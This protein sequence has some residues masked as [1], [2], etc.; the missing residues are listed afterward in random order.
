MTKRPG[1]KAV[2]STWKGRIA[3]IILLSLITITI[4]YADNPATGQTTT[5]QKLNIFVQNPA[6]GGT[7][8][9]C[10][11]P[12]VVTGQTAIGELNQSANVSLAMPVTTSTATAAT[13]IFLTVRLAVLLP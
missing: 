2:L 12:L 5:G 4:A 8:N 13:V 7:V 6:N 10:D 11:Q 9:V 3:L 1:L